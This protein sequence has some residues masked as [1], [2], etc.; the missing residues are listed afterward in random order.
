VSRFGSAPQA[1]VIDG[2]LIVGLYALRYRIEA[3]FLLLSVAGAGI[4][5]WLVKVLVRRPRPAGPDVHVLER[6]NG[7]SFPSGHVVSY[8]ALFGFL[9]YLVVIKARSPVLHWGVVS[10]CLALLVLIGPSRIYLGAHWTSDV[11]GGYLLGGLWLSGVLHAYVA[12][13]DA[14]P[15][16]SAGNRSIPCPHRAAS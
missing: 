11:F 1:V 3:A 6:V 13:Q 7:F 4:L 15:G 8:V 9:A 2:A 12:W 10:L 16:A 14:A 5:V